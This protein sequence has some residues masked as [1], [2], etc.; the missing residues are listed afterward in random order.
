M[1]H[2][3]LDGRERGKKITQCLAVLER[4]HLK[5]RLDASRIMLQLFSRSWIPSF[6]E[7][8][9]PGQRRR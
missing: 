5:A 7:V 6:W 1:Q 3:I 4:N 2:Q 9:S 8:M